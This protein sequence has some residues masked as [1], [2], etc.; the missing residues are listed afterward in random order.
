MKL[1][2]RARLR[3]FGRAAAELFGDK[4]TDRAAALTYYGILAIFPGLLV[5][6][7][8]FTLLGSP[9]ARSIVEG[10][11]SLSFGPTTQ[12]LTEGI[13]HVPVTSRRELGIVALVSLGIALYSST[14]YVGAFIR[15]AY[16]MY[17]G[18]ESRP[19]WRMIPIRFMVTLLTGTFLAVSALVVVFTGR[20]ATGLGELLGLAPRKVQ[21]L[22]VIR[23]P[24]LVVAFGL[25]LA[26]LY[27]TAPHSRRVGFR[28]I[29]AGT[30]L[31]TTVWVIVSAGFAFYVANFDSYNRVYGAL[32]GVIIFLVWTW[33]TN[34]AVLFG[35]EFD[36][37]LAR[38]REVLSKVT[39]PELEEGEAEQGAYYREENSGALP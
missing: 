23:W 24:V 33:L 22:T 18:N 39:P 30:I 4:L 13:S 16:D 28:W 25:L 14:G 31:G 26:L 10:V 8:A 35:A 17:D 21:L 9:A 2:R 11:T 1:S 20:L 29:T 27:W 6:V 19:V 3:A 34:V 12:V 36:A 37:E 38:E 15:A 32:G 7:A 5:L